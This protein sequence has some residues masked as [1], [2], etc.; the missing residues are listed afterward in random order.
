MLSRNRKLVK[1]VATVGLVAFGCV[2]QTAFA[3]SNVPQGFGH[4]TTG[5][6]GGQIVTVTTRQQLQNALCGK[7]NAIGLCGDDTPRTIVVSGTIDFRGEEGSTSGLGCQPYANR[8]ESLVLLNSSD[9]HCNGFKESQIP[10]DKVGDDPML[11]GSNK[12]LIS[13]DGKGVIE[14][15]GLR[16]AQVKNVIIR[17]LTIQN[18]N[19]SVIFAGDA[20]TLDTVDNVWIDHNKFFML[21]RQMIAAGF[22][23]VTH[24]TVSWNDFDGTTPYAAFGNG[25]HYWNML[26]ESTDQSVTIADNWIHNFA[27]RAPIIMANGTT[28]RVNFQIVNNYFQNGCWHA[29]NAYSGVNVLVEG[30]YYEQVNTPILKNTSHVDVGG[31]FALVNGTPDPAAQQQCEKELGR[32]CGTNFLASVPNIGGF[33]QNEGVLQAFNSLSHVEKLVK[34]YKASKVPALVQSQAGPGHIQVSGI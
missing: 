7:L 14:G 3:G 13:A 34:P 9:T 31:V 20:I 5:G 18:I 6:A 29:L 19:P 33:D 22:G 11:V 12:T 4:D 16:L 26:F 27:G 17:N 10:Y 32:T 25:D 30:N 24:V 23:P 28:G 15:R 8:E 21:G 1:T 2:A